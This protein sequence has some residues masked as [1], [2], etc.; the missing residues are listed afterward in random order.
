MNLIFDATL[1]AFEAQRKEAL[2]ELSIHFLRVNEY[3]RD[4]II[5]SVKKLDEAESC[6]ETLM[7]NFIEEE[8]NKDE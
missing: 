2:A 4:A 5:N 7:K 1:S 6:I 3:D 8:E